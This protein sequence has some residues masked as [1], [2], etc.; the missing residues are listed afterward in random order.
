MP[1][2]DP[3]PSFFAAPLPAETA[4]YT[5]FAA[6][7]D[8]SIAGNPCTVIAGSQ[9][10]LAGI[11][12]SRL[13]QR[14]ACLSW[15]VDERVIIAAR[16]GGT[17]TATR[18][19]VGVVNQESHTLLSFRVV[20]TNNGVEVQLCGHGLLATAHYWLDRLQARSSSFELSPVI[21]RDA[22]VLL[23]GEHVIYV[24]DADN[25]TALDAS[26][27]TPQRRLLSASQT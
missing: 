18:E 17:E 27:L 8:A 6:A 5:V 3:T 21:A 22:I 2:A 26:T 15:P 20:C 1:A 25:K 7:A 9:Q 24:C 19:S 16:S 13:A 11:E 12:R 14:T 4:G 10:D 23:M